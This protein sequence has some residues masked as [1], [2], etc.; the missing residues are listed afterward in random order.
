[1]ENSRTKEP[2]DLSYRPCTRG[3]ACGEHVEHVEVDTPSVPVYKDLKGSNFVQ[4]YK[5]LE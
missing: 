5:V 2:L 1:M 3:R 4:K